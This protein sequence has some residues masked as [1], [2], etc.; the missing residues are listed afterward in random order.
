M[1]NTT[2]PIIRDRIID[3]RRVRAGDLIAN[4]KNW[5]LH[6][7]PQAD[8]MRGI[9]RDVGYTTPLMAVE[10]ADGLML[11]DG[12]LRAETTPDTMVPVSIVDL[13]PEE[14]DKVLLTHDPLSAMAGADNDRL[15][16]LLAGVSTQDDAVRRLL[17]S[18]RDEHIGVPPATGLTDPEAVPE[19]VE[20]AVTNS[21]DA[22][23]LVYDPFLGSGTTLIA[24]ER[25]GRRCY[26][27]EIEPRYVDVAVRR[28]EQ[29]TGRTA[30]LA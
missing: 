7:K 3:T 18:I 22:G 17:D 13:T 10:T 28:W 27:M 2:P 21:S 9:L 19:V 6:P 12:H 25:L 24:C 4:P 16:G 8:A 14:A 30:V 15:A 26:A 5:R 23:H 1:P 11:L 29:F 20:R